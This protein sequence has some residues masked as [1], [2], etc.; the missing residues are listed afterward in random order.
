MPTRSEFAPVSFSCSSSQASLF[1]FAALSL[2]SAR[3]CLHR[4]SNSSSVDAIQA[5]LENEQGPCQ[6]L[7]SPEEHEESAS[8]HG[9]VA[10]AS[11]S[12]KL[13]IPRCWTPRSLVARRG[14][15]KGCIS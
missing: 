6:Q 10:E 12:E 8:S 9:E 11:S 2:D 4:A 7:V 14:E 15:M 5:V 1:R 13:P 3:Y